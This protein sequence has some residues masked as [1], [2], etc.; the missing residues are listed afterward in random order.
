MSVADRFRRWFDYEKDV[1]GNV[2]A[3]LATVPENAR[4]HA[5]YQKA[6]D[7]LAHVAAARAMW[8]FRFGASETGPENDD[9]LFPQGK[10]AAEVE[11]A[12]A[13]MHARWSEFLESVDD[14][15]LAEDFEYRATEGDRFR[16]RVEDLLAQLYGHSWYHRGQIASIVRSLGGEPAVTDFVFWSRESIDQG[17]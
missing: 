7:L 13:T 2:V 14:D 5:E 8:L 4:S 11:A 10:T 12:L 6:L 17:D 16:N 9:E 3:S 1:H 15:K